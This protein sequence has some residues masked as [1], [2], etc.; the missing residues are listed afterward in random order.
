MIGWTIKP[1]AGAASQRNG[2]SSG[3]ELDLEPMLDAEE[4]GAHVED[5]EQR[6]VGLAGLARGGLVRRDD[7]LD[8]AH[9]ATS[10]WSRAGL[11]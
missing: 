5:L 9:K 3:R 7:G 10:P 6:E 8:T 11:A 2:I 4:T 1:V